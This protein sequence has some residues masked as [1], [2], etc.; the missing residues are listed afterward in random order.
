[1][2]EDKKRR[3]KKN[4]ETCAY[5]FFF[6]VGHGEMIVLSRTEL[7]LCPKIKNALENYYYAGRFCLQPLCLPT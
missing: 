7:E 3:K 1:M 2:D 6:G 4:D 5:Q